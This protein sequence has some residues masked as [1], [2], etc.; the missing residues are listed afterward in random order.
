MKNS[1]N[2]LSWD[3]SALP[4]DKIPPAP[5]NPEVSDSER[6]LG[7]LVYSL[8]KHW[9][10]L[11]YST[12]NR[13]TIP[14]P[15]LVKKVL[16]IQLERIGDLVVAEPA[17][18]AIRRHYPD[19]ERTLVAP[20]FAKELFAG[21]G[22]GRI[23][24]ASEL[25]SLLQDSTYDLLIDL[26][27]RLEVKLA[28][29]FYNS[30]IPNRVGLERGGR[31]VFHTIPV[32]YPNI[33]LTTAEVYLRITGAI[34]A[35]AEDHI[36]RLPR[37]TKR[38]ERGY[39]LWQTKKLKKPIVMMPGAHFS[40]QR[41]PMDRFIEAGKEL[42]LRG[43]E[44]AVISGPGEDD[45]GR[46]LSSLVGCPWFQSP[47]M[48]QFLDLLAT[49]KLGICNN[50]GPLHIAAALALPTVSTMGPTVPWRWWPLSDAPS[51]VL[52]GGSQER[53]A[54]LDDVTVRELLD[55]VIYLLNLL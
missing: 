17:L 50:T 49:A 14:P 10:K 12:N 37:D 55:S 47:T 26:T 2:E 3:P 24:P 4:G 22:F 25:E 34:G 8:R 40:L 27:G 51:I 7:R 31:G 29:R 13:G 19:A 36:P 1:S 35:T 53:T 11:R 52:R 39:E 42:Q 28:K 5:A 16:V 21:S 33:T 48:T 46:S 54:N 41:W 23:A 44:V 38:L 9:L 15:D 43:E 18:R 45:M 30:A 20:G 6:F 32:P